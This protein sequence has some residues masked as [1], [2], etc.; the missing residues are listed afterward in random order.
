MV[1]R[2][3]HSIVIAAR[4]AEENLATIIQ[5]LTPGMTDETEVLICTERSD[6][7]ADNH[8]EMPG[9][10]YLTGRPGASI[11]EL[12]RDGIVAARGRAVALL[13]AHCI[14][15][16]AWL[17]QLRSL[18]LDRR[19]A[20]GGRIVEPT[21]AGAVSRAI[22]RL[23]YFGASA[24]EGGGEVHEIAADNALYDRKE[25]M[26]CTDLLAAGFWEPAYHARF[27]AR[28]RLLEYV[29]DW[30]VTHANRYTSRQFMR[31]RRFHGRAFGR[32]RAEG[33]SAVRR[34]LMLI[35][36]PA[37][38]PVFAAK[39]TARI[40]ARPDLRTGFLSAAPWFYLFLANW[41]L[42]EMRG[43]ADMV[44]GRDR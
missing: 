34:W 15:S 39:V 42:G 10:H 26:R 9:L 33:A 24:A 21:D 3:S 35:A 23:R 41:S 38:F 11:P 32:E 1:A 31:Q 30:C 5:R 43:Y 36:S 44:L 40:I 29:P 18:D 13:T 8:P 28:G 7:A 12:W 22:H 17:A 25:I 2:I 27:R 6:L 19:G 37:A 14:P 20:Y 4:D 16:D